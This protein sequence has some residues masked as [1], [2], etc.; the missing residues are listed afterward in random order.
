MP[1]EQS[2]WR[3]REAGVCEQPWDD[4]DDGDGFAATATA[5]AGASEPI[6]S[7]GPLPTPPWPR[8]SAR[9]RAQPRGGRRT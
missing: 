2:P 6:T 1:V 9:W 3:L 5:L 7:A 4:A 8:R